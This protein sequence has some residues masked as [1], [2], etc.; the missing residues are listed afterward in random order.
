[1]YLDKN[2]LLEII[3]GIFWKGKKINIYNKVKAIM[4]LLNFKN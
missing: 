3:I 4:N 2:M 1:M